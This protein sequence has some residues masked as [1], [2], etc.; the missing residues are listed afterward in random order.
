MSALA[1]SALYRGLLWG[2]VILIPTF[3]LGR[4]FCGW[5]CPLGTLNHFFSQFKSERKRGRRLID[6]Q[7][8]RPW[9]TLKYYVLIAVLAAALFGVGLAGILDPISLT[10]RSLALSVLPGLNY[11][12]GGALPLGLEANNRRALCRQLL[13]P[14]GRANAPL[15]G[16]TIGHRTVHWAV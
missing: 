2:L 6:S 16:S 3:F 7:R 15:S 4:F 5:I 13:Q 1:S 10:V 11:A 14:D 8:Y 9:Q 12:L